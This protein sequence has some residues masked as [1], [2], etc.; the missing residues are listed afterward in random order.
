[1]TAA[2]LTAHAALISFLGNNEVTLGRVWTEESAR[3]PDFLEQ[4]KMLF[5][6]EF[7]TFFVPLLG[8]IPVTKDGSDFN[9]HFGP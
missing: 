7:T 9:D 5:H 1:M 3:K 2:P 6:K 8:S 4:H